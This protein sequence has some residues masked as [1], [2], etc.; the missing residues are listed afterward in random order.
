MRFF[1]LSKIDKLYFRHE[2]IAR[3]LDISPESAKVSANRYVKQGLLVRVKRNIYVLKEK[4]KVLD[5]E[6]TFILANLGQVP[7]YISLMTALDYYEITTQMQRDFIESVAV[8]RT[9][10]IEVEDRIFTYTKISA[11]LYYGFKRVK[12]F[13]IATPEKAFLDAFYLMSLG[14]Y[15]FDVAS[16]DFSKFDCGEI[17]RSIKKYPTKTQKLLERN[18]YFRK[19]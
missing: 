11:N 18:G 13:F 1:E 19:T 9:K 4:W 15:N 14:R 5:R 17:K 6:E 12:D 7:S 2:D 8:K 16:L 10:A 3:A